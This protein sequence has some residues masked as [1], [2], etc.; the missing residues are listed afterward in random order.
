MRQIAISVL[1]SFLPI[2]EIRGA[3]PYLFIA[4]DN[5]NY[6][7]P[8]IILSVLSNMAVP[9]VAFKVLDV[10]D[11]L[12]KHRSIPMIIKKIYHKILE[13]GNKKAI[14]LRKESYIALALFVGIPLPV[15]G[16]WTGTLV[17]Y[18][19]GL[20]RRKS[21]I[22]IETGVLIASLIILVVILLGITILRTIFMI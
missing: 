18:I 6:L 16:A 14:K 22:A 20:D 21:I 5:D 11:I 13:I 1:I 2:T 15:T 8:G 12:V 9:L 17:A 3:L 10:L 4:I 19:L 7:I